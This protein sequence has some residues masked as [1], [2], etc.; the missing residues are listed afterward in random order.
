MVFQPHQ[1]R[2]TLSLFD[3]FVEVLAEADECLVA[4]IYGARESAELRAQVCAADLV[5][6]VRERGTRCEV[7]GP[8]DG[9]RERIHDLRQPNDL[10]LILGAGDIDLV[11]ADVVATL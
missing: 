3:D 6:R 4:E 1:H 7:A 11:V 9:L 10:V 2:R 8:L 5:S